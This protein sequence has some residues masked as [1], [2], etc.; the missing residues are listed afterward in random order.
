VLSLGKRARR[1]RQAL[2]A[3][4]A[5]RRARRLL[6]ETREEKLR[7]LGGLLL[8]MFRRDRFREDLISERCEEL[9]ALEERLAE[10]DAMLAAALRR[11]PVARCSCGSPLPFRAHFCPNCGRPAG[12]PV[13][14]CSACGHALP[15]DA[16][17]CPQCG[18]SAAAARPVS[19][20]PALRAEAQDA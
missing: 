9:L 13:V 6:A 12:V 3:P 4:G 19:G 20:E 1:R 10:L 7:D 11:P 15:A 2:P 14:A 18:G 8:E 16:S 17:F 5:I